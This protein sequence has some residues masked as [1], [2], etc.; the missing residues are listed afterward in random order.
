MPTYTLVQDQGH[1]TESENLDEILSIAEVLL[2][3]SDKPTTFTV[4]DDEGMAIAC[5]TN[6]RIMGSLV[7]QAWG[8][9][10]NDEAIFIEEVE[11]NATDT[12]LN[13]LSLDAIHAMKDGDYS[14]DQL[15]LMHI[16]WEGPLDV[17]VVDP[18]KKYFGVTSLNKITE[19][20]LSHA[21]GVSS[22]RPM[23]EETVTLTIDVKISM[24]EELDDEARHDLLT[25][26]IHNLDYDI[27]SNTVGVAV[28]STEITG[29]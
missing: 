27:N 21:R 19:S 22:P 2:A 28:K 8:G 6:R 3:G 18:I 24:M 15:G 7:K 26:F 9:R 29:C 14:S 1:Y 16:E 20:C 13:K 25:S 12:V 5:F 4:L 23:V 11:F 10:K 17:K